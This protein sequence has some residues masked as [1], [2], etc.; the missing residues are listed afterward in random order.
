MGDADKKENCISFGFASD[1]KVLNFPVCQETNT[2]RKTKESSR[3]AGWERRPELRENC[4]TNSTE[5]HGDVAKNYFYGRNLLYFISSS[6]GG[7]SLWDGR[8]RR[9]IHSFLANPILR[10]WILI[11][12]IL[13]IRDGFYVTRQ[14]RRQTMVPASKTLLLQL[15]AR[16]YHGWLYDAYKLE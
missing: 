12:T 15:H 9:G 16:H 4:R 13:V 6:T 14:G 3:F 1:T 5:E 11:S 2:P 10:N 8:R 7:D